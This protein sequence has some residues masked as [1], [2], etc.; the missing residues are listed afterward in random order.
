M[1]T[2]L[3][4]SLAAAAFVATSSA[5]SIEKGPIVGERPDDGREEEE[6]EDTLAL[7]GE[8]HGEIINDANQHIR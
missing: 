2:Y 6:R 1:R 4:L 5:A 8:D 7:A 3:L